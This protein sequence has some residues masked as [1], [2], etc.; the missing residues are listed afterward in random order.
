MRV[1]KR[2]QL[3]KYG[4]KRTGRLPKEVKQNQLIEQKKVVFVHME[5]MH[6]RKKTYP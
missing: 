4:P 6:F 5:E 3:D 1:N 2:A